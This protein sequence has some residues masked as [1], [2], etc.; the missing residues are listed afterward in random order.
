MRTLLNVMTAVSLASLLTMATAS[1]AATYRW[2]DADGVH[3]S[4]QPHP[5]A[6]KIYLGQTQTYSAEPN[7][8]ASGAA[9]PARPGQRSLR[10]SG[11]FR[12][13]SCNVVQP[14]E[15]QVFIDVDTATIGVAVRPAKRSGDRV[16]LSLD[17]Q[18]KEP[19]SNEQL[20]F[21]ITPI[22]RGTHVVAATVRDASGKDLC[23]S[24][25]VTFHVRQA[26]VLAP[27][28]PNRPH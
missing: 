9:Q 21:V 20:E 6:E 26:S 10:A 7:A 23:Q 5:G 18:I 27:Q 28:N 15:D 16:V 3:Y 11:P 12:Y 17:G 22:E 13:D 19:A 14:A 25:T 24:T 8:A 1:A 2:V 4:D